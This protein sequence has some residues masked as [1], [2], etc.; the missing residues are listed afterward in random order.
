VGE[1]IIGGWYA[2]NNVTKESVPLRDV[3]YSA[4]DPEAYSK[5]CRRVEAI[6]KLREALDVYDPVV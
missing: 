3:P 6:A 1:L 5:A 4:Y 2:V